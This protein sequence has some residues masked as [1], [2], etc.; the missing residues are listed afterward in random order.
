MLA[1]SAFAQPVA[2][3]SVTPMKSFAY[4]SGGCTNT[5]AALLTFGGSGAWQMGLGSGMAA[6]GSGTFPTGD[7]YVREISLSVIGGS[8]GNWAV[9]GHSGPNGDWVTGAVQPG[10]TK[11]FRFFQ[12]A[13]PLFTAGEYFDAHIASCV[14][15]MSILVVFSWVPAP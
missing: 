9:I 4:A 1:A 7:F 10:Q 6:P 3:Q 11:T 2:A 14:S 8:P 13:A 12:D 15:G 5:P